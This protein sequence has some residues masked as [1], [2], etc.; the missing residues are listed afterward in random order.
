MALTKRDAEDMATFLQENDVKASYIHSDLNTVERADALKSLQNSTIDCLVGVNLMREGIDLPQVS[1]VAIMSADNQG[2][3][4]SETALLQMVGRAARNVNGQAIFYAD[5]I[6]KA[7]KSAI[8]TTNW[9]REK[10]ASFNSKNNKIPISAKGSEIKSIFDIFREE[11]NV[12]ELGSDVEWSRSRSPHKAKGSTQV[13]ATPRPA[14]D[15]TLEE[16]TYNLPAKTGIYKWMTE[17]D[18]VTLYIGKAKNLSSRCRSYLTGKDER[19]RINEMMKKVKWV[20]YII[21]PTEQDALN[22]EAKLINLHQPPYNVA[23]KDDVSFPYIVARTSDDFPRFERVPKI[24]P[25]SYRT[26]GYEYYGPYSTSQEADRILETIEDDYN[27][28][29]LAFEAK[30]GENRAEATARYLEEFENC[31]AVLFESEETRISSPRVDLLFDEE[32]NHSRDIVGIVPIDPDKKSPREFLVRVCQLR[33]GIYRGERDFQFKLPAGLTEEERERELSTILFKA[34]ERHYQDPLACDTPEQ[35]S[36]LPF[37]FLPDSILA[38]LPISPE[39]TKELKNIFRFHPSQKSIRP[40]KVRSLA[41]RGRNKNT[42]AVA[43]QFV[44][45]N[46]AATAQE[47]REIMPLS[48]EQRGTT[49]KMI[50]ERSKNLKTMLHLPTHPSRIECYDVSHS[51]GEFSTCSRVVFIDGKPEKSLYRTF[52]IKSFQGNDDYRSLTEVL[53]RRF[54]RAYESDSDSEWAIPDL[55]V[56]DGGKGQLSAAYKGIRAAG[57]GVSGV[58]SNYNLTVPV[59]AIAKRNE[60]VFALS[61]SDTP[62]SPLNKSPDEPGVLMLRQIRDE[63][64]RFAITRMRARRRRD[65]LSDTP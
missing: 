17:R 30:N 10:Q 28:R 58:D 43:M 46:L 4:R 45:D 3:L 26:D 64:H 59:C 15:P 8:D 22:L 44:T 6:T 23:L 63:S 29:K 31:K 50:A 54:K 48:L 65:F 61:N 53:E 9:R 38:M 60:E 14:L 25:P 7:M 37:T 42:D 36:S 2:F 16:L 12:E 39:S 51:Q 52:N 24:P 34:L 32:V 55:V 47:I 1:L 33:K 49:K 11:M 40:P 57:V 35:L 56:I 19:P 13:V 27:L 20:E 18:G 5:K 21:T 41:K 62:L